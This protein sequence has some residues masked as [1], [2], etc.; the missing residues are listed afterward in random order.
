[1]KKITAYLIMIIILAFA[2]AGCS[3][4]ECAKNGH[5]EAVNPAIEP[6]CCSVGRTE[7]KHCSVCGE[8]IVA[9]EI[10]PA[11]GHTEVI[12][13]GTNPTCTEEG[14]TEGK[15]C[16]VCGEIIVAQEII[17]AT[18]HTEVIDEGTTPTCTE[19]GKTDGKHCSVCG[20][21]IVAQE[22][23]PAAGHTEVVDEG[24]NPTC[25]EEGKTEG[26]H[27]SVCGEVIVAQ[28]IIPA[29]GHTE[30]IDE[31][32]NPTCTEVGW[33]EGKHCSVCGEVIVAQ[34]IIPATGHTEATDKGTAATCTEV[35]WTEGKHCSVCGEVIA[36]Q[37]IIPASG[38][39]YGAWTTVKAATCISK[40]SKKRTCACGAYETAE[41][42]L[43]DHTA[44]VDAAVPATSTST[45]LTEG[46]HCSV[47]GKVLVEQ[48]VTDK[49]KTD[50]WNLMLVNPWN[51]IPSGYVDGIKLKKIS[52]SLS[53]DER[54][55]D[56]LMKMLSDCKAA[57]NDPVVCSAFRTNETQTT[58]FNNN[59]QKL[60]NKGYTYE[61][62]YA[63]TA[64]GTAVPGTSE[65]ELGLAVD[66]V[67]YSNWNLN[68]SQEKTGT[69]KWLMANSWKY[70]F[71][72]R[73]PN[74]KSS[75]TGIIYEPW[76]YRYVGVDVA[77]EIYEAGVTLEEYLEM[78]K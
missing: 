64:K 61:A 5:V 34:A 65:H 28:E 27:C 71:I 66:I 59:V 74:D 11:T 32:T 48:K 18:G 51:S 22:I 16:S 9:Q 23:I 30:V 13:E 3:V 60:V 37:A 6:S 43:S 68:S 10:I 29:T 33:T 19:E 7:G 24:T 12:D 36:A 42:P 45:G 63:E 58:L 49:I 1:M 70:G 47:C 72:L 50:S 54:C 17:P 76:H 75:V 41:I 14:K 57:G 26:K 73:Y 8:A 69:Q 67:C 40:G 4:D 31:G 77:K 46:K 44:V 62:A 15:H 25:T 78:K 52:S 56:A 35:G 53:I 20:E 2:F 55:Y 39:S 38:H 21:I